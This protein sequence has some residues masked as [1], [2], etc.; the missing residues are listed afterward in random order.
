MPKA[1]LKSTE[2]T[3]AK[4]LNISDVLVEQQL[5]RVAEQN[6]LRRKVVDSPIRATVATIAYTSFDVLSM[7]GNLANL[8]NIQCTSMALETA[9]EVEGRF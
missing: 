9:S 4:P 5:S 7:V 6:D 2:Q 8:V 3:I 1:T